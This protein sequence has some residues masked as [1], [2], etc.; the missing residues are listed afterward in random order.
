MAI[1]KELVAA[2]RAVEKANFEDEKLYQAYV[3]E[4]DKYLS[5]I[6]K[7]LKLEQCKVVLE[8]IHY[9]AD[10]EKENVPCPTPEPGQTTKPS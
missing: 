5:P 7:N 3:I 10:M 4:R 9:I 6:K 2:F 8:L 1:S